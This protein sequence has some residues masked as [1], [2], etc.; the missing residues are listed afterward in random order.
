M[1]WFRRKRPEPPPA[2]VHLPNPAE[3]AVAFWERWHALLPRISGALGDGQPQRVEHELCELVASVHPRLEFAIQRGRRAVYALVLSSREDP[4]VRPYTDAW[5]AAA[6]HEDMIWEYHD[7]VP[8]VPDT[9][10]VTVN[11]GEHRLPLADIRLL[12]EPTDDGVVDVVVHHPVFADLGEDD[13]MR[14]AFLAL[15]A[16]LGERV[17]AGVVGRV[18]LSLTDGPRSITLPQFRRA[19]EPPEG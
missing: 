2:P 1:R 11:I 3:A 4:V 5:R 12:T 10:E 16:A 9:D 14:V 17:A 7:S 15:D 19:F 6:P 13:R 8:P 18:E